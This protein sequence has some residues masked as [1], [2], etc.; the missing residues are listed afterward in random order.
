MRENPSDNGPGRPKILSSQLVF[1][2]YVKINK[3]YLE[4]GNGHHYHYYTLQISTPAALILARTLKG[5]FVLIKEYR[6]PVRQ[7]IISLPGGY[8]DP[9]E[10]PIEAAKRE[11]L[12]EAGYTADHF[13]VMGSS[14]PY[15]GLSSQLIYYI[16]A[17]HAHPAAGPNREPAEFIETVLMTKEQLL[18]ELQEHPVDGNL[19]TALQWLSVKSEAQ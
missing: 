9:G 16:A 14:Y 17:D 18:K 19:L 7:T 2:E 13:R 6:H 1:D 4:N 8:I 12:E 15:P 11:L 10:T 5:E 3:D